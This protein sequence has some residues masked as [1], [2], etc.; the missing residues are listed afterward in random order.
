MRK[1]EILGLQWKHIDL[2]KRMIYL[3]PVDTKEGKFKRV[4]IHR[5]L[6]PVLEELKNNANL[7]PETKTKYILI[8]KEIM[9]TQTKLIDRQ[10]VVLITNFPL[11]YSKVYLLNPF[12]TLPCETTF[13]FNNKRCNFYMSEESYKCINST[14][15]DD[16]NINTV[17]KYGLPEYKTISGFGIFVN[18]LLLF[19]ELYILASVF[20]YYHNKLKGKVS[21]KMKELMEVSG[22]LLAILILIFAVLYYIYLWRLL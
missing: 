19:I 12:F 1:G 17:F 2:K 15:T 3:R 7:S 6:V 14:K 11:I 4:P 10:K 18:S 8:Q 20:I 21:H 22:I 13:L 5:E 9:D 16:S